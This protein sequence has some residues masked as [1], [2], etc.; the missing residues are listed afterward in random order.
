[1]VPSCFDLSPVYKKDLEEEVHSE[2]SGVY[3]KILI[4]VCQGNRIEGEDDDSVN[5]EKAAQDARDLYDVRG[6][7]TPRYGQ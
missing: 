2:T 4:S 5:K 3:R 1:M 7:S 6:C